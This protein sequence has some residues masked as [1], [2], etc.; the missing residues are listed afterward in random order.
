MCNL[1]RHCYPTGPG[2]IGIAR[3]TDDQP[4]GGTDR[5]NHDAP[6][7]Q[8]ATPDRNLGNLGRER[9]DADYVN[10]DSLGW[11]PYRIRRERTPCSLSSRPPD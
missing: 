9:M 7:P 4:A 10:S 2:S 11:A 8:T 5:K 1:R 6:R 3:R